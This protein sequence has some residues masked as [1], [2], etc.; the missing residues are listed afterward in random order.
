MLAATNQNLKEGV[1]AGTFRADL[2]YRLNVIPLE[3]PP[4]R[5]R[6][7]DIAPL[8]TFFLDYYCKRYSR[9]KVLSRRVIEQLK[10]YDWPG[11]IRELKN[12]VERLLGH[13]RR[14]DA[15]DLSGSGPAAGGGCR[16]LH[17]TGDLSRRLGG[18]ISLTRSIS[19]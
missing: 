18:S 11:N 19:P 4:L 10:A 12:V 2:Y 15:G 8:A 5:E 9:T 13:Q 16:P 6:R 17:L 7:E 14:R 3:L 1:L